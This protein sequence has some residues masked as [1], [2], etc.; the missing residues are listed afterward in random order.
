MGTLWNVAQSL[1]WSSKEDGE[2]Q[3]AIVRWAIAMPYAMKA[4]CWKKRRM[5]R[6][7]EVR[8]LLVSMLRTCPCQALAGGGPQE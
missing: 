6:D 4:H 5:Q 1:A 8:A 3:E 7:L 2:M